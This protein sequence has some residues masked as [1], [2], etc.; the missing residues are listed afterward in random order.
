MHPLQAY[1]NFFPDFKEKKTFYIFSLIKTATKILVNDSMDSRHFWIPF[2][3][4][5]P[6]DVKE[7][8]WLNWSLED[9]HSMQVSVISTHKLDQTALYR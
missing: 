5:L 9:A 2:I 8:F 7:L 6:W 1:S 4:H 3:P